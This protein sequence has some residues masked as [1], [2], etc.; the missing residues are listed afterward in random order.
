MAAPSSLV[1]I[2]TVAA[3]VVEM[4][5]P[6]CSS[7]RNRQLRA[8][9]WQRTAPRGPRALAQ[10]CRHQQPLQQPPC[11]AIALTMAS[12]CSAASLLRD[13]VP[14][15]GSVPGSACSTRQTSQ[16]SAAGSPLRLD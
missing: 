9:E 8:V 13:G 6:H 1:L 10:R 11:S 2:A 7:F 3:C 15:Q 12:C 16:F 4:M 5:Y 14:R